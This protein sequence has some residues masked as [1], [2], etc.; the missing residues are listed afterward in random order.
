M[1]YSNE[2]TV[3][4]GA[5]QGSVLGPLLFLLFTND[6]YQHLDHCGSI[7]FADDTTIYMTHRNLNYIN[8]C[9]GH[10]LEK[11]SD[12]FKANS[13]TLNLSKTVSMLFKNK[14]SSGTITNIRIDQTKIPLVHET[15]FLGIW[16]DERLMWVAHLN[17][18]SIKIKR[19]IHL[20]RN[21]RNVLDCH[22]LKLIYLT[23]I[24][25]HINYGLV[26]WGSMA[27]AEQLNKI[28]NMQIE[29]M[30]LIKPKHELQSIYKELQILS[31]D[32]LIELEYKKLAYK[33]SKNLL[34]P[35][36]LE[37]ISSDQQNTSLKK[38]HN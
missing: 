3:E 7:L 33:F 20:L 19:N 21:H 24:K 14:K 12:W 9:L 22:T 27:N 18:L 17:K 8:F 4:Y 29:C 5:P 38:T 1:A 2:Y 32:Q 23:Q 11:I 13:L 25:S 15:K 31:V 6:L 36:I 10:D 34:P 37:I 35:K 28:K 26:L 16:L 30:K